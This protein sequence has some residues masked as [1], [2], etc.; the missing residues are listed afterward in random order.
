MNITD[1]ALTVIIAF[2]VYH[3]IVLERDHAKEKAKLINTII[4]KNT[5]EKI[6]LDNAL[7]STPKEPKKPE[8]QPVDTLTNEEWE[9]AVTQEV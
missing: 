9:K 1:I 7:D 6:T 4:A 2:L 8:L 5:Q 3:N